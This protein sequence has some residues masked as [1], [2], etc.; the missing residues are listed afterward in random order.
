MQPDRTEQ[1]IGLVLRRQPSGPRLGEF[2]VSVDK[3]V[4]PVPESEGEITRQ[5]PHPPYEGSG[6][7][8]DQ[9]RLHASA[10]L[11]NAS[12]RSLFIGHVDLSFRECTIGGRLERDAPIVKA[13]AVYMQWKRQRVYIL[14]C[15]A[16]FAV[17]MAGCRPSSS[18]PEAPAA[19]H[20]GIEL[21]IAC[22]NEA[23]EALL[24]RYG[25]PWALRQGVKLDL[26]R[27]DPPQE[28][29]P[30]DIWILAPADLPRWAAAGEL[31]AVPERYAAY[32]NPY[33]WS[34]LLPLYRDQADGL[35]LWDGVPYGLP[36]L[37][38][39]PLCCYREDLL[40]SPAHQEALRKRLGRA[41]D[42]PATWE[43]FAQ[44]AEYFH[45][46][47]GEDKESLP[48]LPRDDDGL[49]R[50]FY[51]V[52]AGFARHAVPANKERGAGHQDDVFSFHYDMKTGRPRLSAP[53][54]VHALKLLQRLQACRPAEPADRPEE[55]FRS[56][57]AVLCLADAPWVKTF[58]ATPAL[59]DKFSISRVPGGERYFDFET[60]EAQP[61]PAGNRVPYL[62]GA[63]WLAVV[64][65]TN[66]HADAAFELLTELSGPLTSN[67]IFLSSGTSGGPL[68][69]EQLDRH[70]WNSFD[71]DDA[72]TP[73]F[74]KAMQDT[75]H[76]GLKNPA[77]CLRTPRQAAHRAALVKE[78]RA[79][80][81]E[82]ADAEKA[83]RNVVEAWEKLDREQGLEAH[84]ADYRRSLGLLAK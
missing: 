47:L 63:G 77:L 51:T 34:D 67:Q 46:Q 15:V 42:A 23:T 2:R 21:R 13:E 82:G 4:R 26:R 59:R 75:L 64:P 17:W 40:K 33:T 5:T 54:F 36:V 22:P 73:Q 79:A 58:Q 19:P 61:T 28:P 31:V 76:H 80:L 48:P 11:R 50:L 57:R 16:P 52:A 41:P 3:R 1:T 45:G 30:A 71:L 18:A 12:S 56:G 43:Q 10:G 35:I 32:N 78:V 84:R 37:G 14:F 6:P 60:G 65:R 20:Q 24:R 74:R 68:R 39:S 44:I 66:A 53:G 62:G 7:L 83:L 81:L 72:R 70:R 9:R 8:E 49:D 25:Q 55:A 27:Y 69:G 38:E 29:K